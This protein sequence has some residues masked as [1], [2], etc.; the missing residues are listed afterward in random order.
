M[1][2]NNMESQELTIKEQ[3]REMVEF[4]KSAAQQLVALVTQNKWAVNISGHDYLRF[5]AW[6]T[7]GR[8]FGYT[9]KTKST[10]YVE[11]GEAK[12]FEATASVLNSK[13]KEVGGAEALC[14]DDENNWKGKPLFSLKSMAQTRASAKA[15][16]QIL[17]WVVVLAGFKPTPAEEVSEQVLDAGASEKQVHAIFAIAKAKH[18]WLSNETEFNVKTYLKIDSFNGMTKQQAS[19]VIG[20]LSEGDDL[21]KIAEMNSVV[22]YPGQ[23]E[24]RGGEVGF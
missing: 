12:G 18:G 21:G 17:A 3:P 10:E 23:E 5:E 2:V 14:L 11:I 20:K 8:F 9:I 6:Q 1:E 24:Y 19:D 15:L 13:G 4:G 7:V 16:R 22:G